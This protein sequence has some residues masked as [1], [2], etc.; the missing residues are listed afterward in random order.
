MFSDDVLLYWAMM[1]IL[2]DELS[3]KTDPRFHCSLSW[4]SC[5][6]TLMTLFIVIKRRLSVGDL[7]FVLG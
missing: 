7:F 6:D 3:V 4:E 2:I 5:S 1:L